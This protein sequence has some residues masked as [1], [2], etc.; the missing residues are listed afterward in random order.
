MDFS[1]TLQKLFFPHAFFAE[2]CITVSFSENEISLMTNAGCSL[3]KSACFVWI[4]KLLRSSPTNKDCAA[5]APARMLPRRRASAT[6]AHTRRARRHRP[7][8]GSVERTSFFLNRVVAAKLKTG[9]K[10]D[11]N[12]GTQFSERSS[13]KYVILLMNFTFGELFWK[14]LTYEFLNL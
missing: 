13:G 2:K 12:T 8:D 6:G 1:K 3:V 5:S 9:K 4:I 14:S 10:Y 7:P 11:Q